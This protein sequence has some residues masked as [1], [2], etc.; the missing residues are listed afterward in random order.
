MDSVL[1]VHLTEIRKKY[2]PMPA[3]MGNLALRFSY[4][5]QW[6]ESEE[7]VVLVRESSR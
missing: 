4:Q 5:G 1:F 3:S 7:L 6:N 2:P